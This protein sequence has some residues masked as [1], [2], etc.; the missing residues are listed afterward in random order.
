M[1]GSN[2]GQGRREGDD[3]RHDDGEPERRRRIN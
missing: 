3:H 1:Q 2:Q